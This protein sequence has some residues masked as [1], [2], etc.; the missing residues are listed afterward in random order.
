VLRRTDDEFHGAIARRDSIVLVKG[1]RQMGKTSLL[2]RGAQRA[3]ESGA[4]VVITDF[5]MLDESQLES[6]DRLLSTLAESIADQLELATSPSSVW[7][8]KRGAGANFKRFIQRDVMGP[9]PTA[10]LWVLDEVD[11][12]FTRP[13]HSEVFG[14]FRSWHNARAFEPNAAW[15]RLT[16]AIAYATEAH[17]FIT[18]PNQSPFNVGTRLALADF[19]CESV[20]DLNSRY[21]GPLASGTEVRRLVDLVGGHPYLVRRSLHHLVT[22]ECGIAE[23]E[24]IADRD[25]GPLGDHL[26]QVLSLVSH[27]KELRSAIRGLLSGKRS[28]SAESFYL[29][30]AAGIVSGETAAEMRP[31]CELYARYLKSHLV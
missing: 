13:F 26:R 3:R 10:L 2:A 16:L 24:L 17:L 15:H 5:Q 28:V 22:H 1:A 12:L 25:D 20:D 18:D 23:F 9:T 14:L 4:R 30:R 21:G 11:R 8:T 27:D 31:R 7:D 29:L 19:T 6:A